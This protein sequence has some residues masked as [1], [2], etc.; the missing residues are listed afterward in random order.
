MENHAENVPQKL[1][2]DP[3]FIL[4]KQPKESIICNKFF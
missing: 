4:E 3:S 2:P 1:I